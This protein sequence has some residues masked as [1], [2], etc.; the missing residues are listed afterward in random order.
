V[1]SASLA[2]IARWMGTVEAPIA[3]L[4]GG[5]FV[6]AGVA[7]LVRFGEFR[8]SLGGYRLARPR[9]LVAAAVPA[10]ELAVGAGLI[11]G[12]P[13]AG[14]AA[15]ALLAAFTAALVVELAAG[16]APPSCGCLPG[17]ASRPAPLT[18]LRNAVLGAAAVAA[19]LGLHPRLGDGFWAVTYVLLWAAV[20]ALAALVLA[21]YR[22]VGVLHLRLGPRGAFEHEGEGLPLGEPAPDGLAGSLVVFTSQACPICA[23][24]VPGLRPLASDHA[25]PVQHALYEDE[26]GRRLH[27]WFMV[28]GT[29]YAVYV[30]NDGLVRA[31]GTVNTLEQLEGVVITGRARERE[32]VD[33]RAA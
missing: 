24:I 19:A 8:E 25:L 33:A 14:W 29:P 30:D 28:P 3:Q 20:I 13:A 26:H 7:K 21:L 1:P 17:V 5:L 12:R 2:S 27:D 4:L 6:V 32:L 18:V 22:Q 10:L 31:K 15:A 11:A 16:S 23:Q 9:S